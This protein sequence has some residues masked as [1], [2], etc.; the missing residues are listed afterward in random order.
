[1]LVFICAYNTVLS[2]IYDKGLD[3]GL[4]VFCEKPPAMKVEELDN[5]FDALIYQEIMNLTKFIGIII[6]LWKLKK[7]LILVKWVSFYG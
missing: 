4:H 1:M 5:V 3:S 7:L 6:L 2:R